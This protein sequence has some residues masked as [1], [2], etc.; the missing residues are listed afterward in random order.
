[1]GTLLELNSKVEDSRF[2]D[3]PM[4]KLMAQCRTTTCPTAQ[5]NLAGDVTGVRGNNKPK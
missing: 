4:M 2:A 5:G 1:M 3:I